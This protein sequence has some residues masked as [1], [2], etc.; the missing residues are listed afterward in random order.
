MT[1]DKNLSNRWAKDYIESLNA[2]IKAVQ[3]AGE[4][5]NV[6]KRLLFHHDAS[7]WSNEEFPHY[8]R[9]F[10]GDKG[11]PESFEKAWLHHI[12]ENPHHW[13]HWIIPD[14]QKVLKMPKEYALEMVADWM[15]SSYVYTGSWD[16]TDWLDKNHSKITLHPE[17]SHYVGTI[18]SALLGYEIYTFCGGRT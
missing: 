14:T 17:T 2:H 10:C 7:K 8:A 1:N 12:H 3:E 18:L 4:K 5:L 13:Q 16:M 11:D 6:P 9:Q 15:G